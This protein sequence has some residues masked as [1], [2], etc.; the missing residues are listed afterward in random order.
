VLFKM[1]SNLCPN[2]C[3]LWILTRFGLLI[4]IAVTVI[5]QDDLITALQLIHSG[6]GVIGDAFQYASFWKWYVTT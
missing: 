1:V 6:F 4:F 5:T 3:G 2:D